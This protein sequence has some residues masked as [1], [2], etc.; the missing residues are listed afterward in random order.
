MHDLISISI[1]LACLAVG[2]WLDAR[3]TV[4]IPKDC[5]V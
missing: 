4:T 2:R 5:E 1:G 3:N